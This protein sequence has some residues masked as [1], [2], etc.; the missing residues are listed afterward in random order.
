MAE[1]KC[2]TCFDT[3][4]LPKR[5]VGRRMYGGGP[6]PDCSAGTVARL[7]TLTQEEHIRG[8]AAAREKQEARREAQRTRSHDAA[9]TLRNRVAIAMFKTWCEIDPN[10]GVAMYPA[11]YMANFVDMADAAIREIE[12]DQAN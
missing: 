9:K 4:T 6:C 7:D 11:S 5:M 12:N 2:Y 1:V 10:S 8:L 3:G